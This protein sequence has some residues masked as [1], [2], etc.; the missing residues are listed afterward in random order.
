MFSNPGGG[1]ACACGL[2]GIKITSRILCDEHKLFQ[3][4]ILSTSSPYL[5]E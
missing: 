2:D 5:R 4:L 3:S 1:R